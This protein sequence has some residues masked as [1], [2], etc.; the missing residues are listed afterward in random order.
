[1]YLYY[2]VTHQDDKAKTDKVAELKLQAVQKG[3][4]S[5]SGAFQVEIQEVLNNTKDSLSSEEKMSQALRI[6]FNRFD[7]DKSGAIDQ[8]ELRI[9][10]QEI[11]EK[12]MLHDE[13]FRNFLD[14]IDKDKN[15]VVDFREFREAFEQAFRQNSG[16]KDYRRSSSKIVSL[17]A[18]VAGF[19]S[20]VQ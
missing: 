16:G 20:D 15:G 8:H 18:K 10:L 17:Q 7:T 4:M 12:E 14:A 2:Q 1:M 9:L 13:H 19:S 6:F 5:F 3:V 11:G